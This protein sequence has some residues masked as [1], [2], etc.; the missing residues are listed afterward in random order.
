LL[1]IIATSRFERENLHEWYQ[2]LGF[3]KHGFEFRIDLK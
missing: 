1:Q 2:G 3:K